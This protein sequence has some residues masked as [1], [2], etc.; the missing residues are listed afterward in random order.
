VILHLSKFR[1]IAD[2][3]VM[4]DDLSGMAR[5]PR[6]RRAFEKLLRLAASRGDADLVAERLGWGID[7]DGSSPGGRTPLIANVRGNSPSAAIV[8][9][10]L[11]AGA[12]PSLTDKHGLSALDYARRKLLRL[13]AKPRRK[14][15]KSPSLDEN[16]QLKLSPVEQ[17]QMDRMRS[18]F[19]QEDQR[20]FVRVYWQER[21]RA[22]RRVFNDPGQVQTIV[23][24][25]EAA[26]SRPQ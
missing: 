5:D 3:S 17:A 14:P 20:E 8:R 11:K 23:S 10:L 9:A 26:E 16:N 21:L 19:S 25:L 22:A 2:I 15:G 7:P 6:H 4:S 12:D 1:S 13:Q 24:L 18:R